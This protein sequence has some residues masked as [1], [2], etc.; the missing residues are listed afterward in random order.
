MS[1]LVCMITSREST[2]TPNFLVSSVVLTVS[3]VVNMLN[4]VMMSLIISET[5][6]VLI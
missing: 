3:I 1:L 5:E 4:S 6:E 2:S